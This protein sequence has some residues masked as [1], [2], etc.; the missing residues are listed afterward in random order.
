MTAAATKYC[1][2][3]GLRPRQRVDTR[4]QLRA[5][6]TKSSPFIPAP[7]W[8]DH[9]PR[10]TARKTASSARRAPSFTRFFGFL[11]GPGRAS[12]T[13]HVI[14]FDGCCCQS[15]T[16]AAGQVLP[17]LAN[18]QTKRIDPAQM[19]VIKREFQKEWSG[20]RTSNPRLL[21]VRP[22]SYHLHKRPRYKGE[23]SHPPR[24]VEGRL[25]ARCRK[26]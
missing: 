17:P 26:S 12:G 6:S 14:S 19:R 13:C 9:Q 3:F 23:V 25:Q 2:Q 20:R 8:H 24:F 11:N 15:R 5:A 1:Q 4:A 16:P 18:L 7:V 10:I 21:R 22:E